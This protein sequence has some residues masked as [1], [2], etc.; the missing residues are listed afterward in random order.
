MKS[1]GSLISIVHNNSFGFPGNNSIHW[2]TKSETST[3]REETSLRLHE[4]NTETIIRDII[5]I[6]LQVVLHLSLMETSF[7]SLLLLSLLCV[8]LLVLERESREQVKYRPKE[9][10][11]L[12][13]KKKKK[14]RNKN[15]KGMNPSRDSL[16]ALSFLLFLFLFFSCV[17]FFFEAKTRNESEEI[18]RED[19]YKK[20]K[21]R[22]K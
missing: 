7:L 3:V 9:N 16:I 20:K 6:G 22:N 21:M 2:Q 5:I 10:R 1:D 14:E 18:A 19:E 11:I 8:L 13:K 12:K 17:L 4:C 15:K